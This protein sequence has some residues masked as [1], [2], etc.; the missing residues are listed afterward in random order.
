VPALPEYGG[1]PINRASDAAAILSVAEYVKASN[2][3]FFATE[4]RGL[5]YQAMTKVI[6]ILRAAGYDAFRVVN[7]QSRAVGDPWRYGSDALVLN[8]I[9]WD[10]YAAMGSPASRP[11]ALNVGPYDPGRPR[12]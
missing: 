8:G 3:Q 5:A 7:H 4:D 1:V 2:P 6:G 12:E 10:V 9:V 11:Q